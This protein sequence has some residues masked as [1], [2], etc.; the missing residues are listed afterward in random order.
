M[1]PEDFHVP[2][3]LKQTLGLLEVGN[4]QRMLDGTLGLG[5]HSQAMLEQSGPTARLVGLDRDESALELAGQ[6][7]EKFGD[8]AILRQSSY[9]EFEE[10]LD[11]LGWNTLDAALLDLGVSSLQLDQAE[12]GFSFISDGPLDMRMDRH[13]GQAPA[14][15]LVN[16]A[17]YARLKEII[18]DLG[19]E[20][21]AGRIARSIVNAREKKP[22]ESTL[23]LAALV[24][25]AYPPK[26]RAL[27]RNHPATRTFMALRMAV[28]EE[29]DELGEF[30]RRI[31]ARMAVGAR[32][33]IISFHSLE[34]RMVKR[35]FRSLAAPC[36]CL[37][38]TPRCICGQGLG[39][40]ILTKKPVQAE[41]AEIAANPRARSAKLR[42]IRRIA[43]GPDREDS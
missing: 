2:V 1:R 38:G 12:R 10:V 25:R 24:E 41:E 20:P 14:S 8:R 6:R 32:L 18:R 36:V 37:P 17:P 28:N 5:G 3:L 19:E 30:L 22:F 13:S 15:R 33:A 4:A 9:S 29:L 27:A 43:P 31:P 39:F 16:K 7:L 11:E 40:E 35:A 23:E 26:W 34:D 42:A 21:Q